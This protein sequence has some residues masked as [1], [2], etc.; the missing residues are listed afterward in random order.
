M[1]TG[2]LTGFI[3]PHSFG[4]GSHPIIPQYIGTIRLSV[5]P[6]WV[7]GILDAKPRV[8]PSDNDAL[9]ARQQ[10]PLYSMAFEQGRGGLTMCVPTIGSPNKL[11]LVRNVGPSSRYNLPNSM[12]IQIQHVRSY[13][14]LNWL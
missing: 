2:S 1:H 14:P 8:R 4:G 13:A 11:V 9:S 10:S 6:R 3:Y 5:M 12:A 7:P